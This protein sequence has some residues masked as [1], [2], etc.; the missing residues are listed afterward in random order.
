MRLPSKVTSYNES[1]L[2]VLLALAKTLQRGDMTVLSLFREC[3]S[4][5][6][7]VADY[8]KTHVNIPT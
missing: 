4:V 8:I 1:I 6:D 2:P 3:K 7:D 5:I